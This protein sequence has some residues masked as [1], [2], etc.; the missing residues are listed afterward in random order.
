MFFLYF[1]AKASLCS[2]SHRALHTQARPGLLYLATIYYN[3]AA[4]LY[5]RTRIGRKKK[6]REN[7]RRV[8]QTNTPT[9][10][11]Q[12]PLATENFYDK[13]RCRSALFL[14][15][16]NLFSCCRLSVQHLL[17]GSHR[18]FIESVKLLLQRA[19][20]GKH[21]LHSSIM[22]GRDVLFVCLFFSAVI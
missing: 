17:H 4:S 7:R 2:L 21:C 20:A 19:A 16:E 11:L 18:A 10:V 6:E 12:T 8:P 1:T 22:S 5:H 13:L 15:N 3:K 14:G 9:L